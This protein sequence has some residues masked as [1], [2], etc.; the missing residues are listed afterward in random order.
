[1]KTRISAPIALALAVISLFPLAAIAGEK[2]NRAELEKLAGTWQITALESNGNAAPPQALEKFK[3]VDVVIKGDAMTFMEGGKAVQELKI[4]VVA[5]QTP[6]TID[7]T[8]TRG[9]KTEVAL[10]IFV[11]EEKKMK[12][13]TDDRGKQRPKE[14]SSKGEGISLLTFERK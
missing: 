13:C 2:E 6:K 14:F 10:G 12:L 5:D 11:R 3:K 7:I 4:A 9:G 8:A 1:M